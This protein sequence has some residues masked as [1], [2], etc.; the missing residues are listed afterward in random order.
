MD[1]PQIETTRPTARG[2]LADVISRESLAEMAERERLQAAHLE[3]RV[4]ALLRQAEQ[5][6]EQAQIHAVRAGLLQE[7][8]EQ[9]TAPA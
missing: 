7:L 5:L 2:I 4:A 8:A 6:A 1:A 9:K 3:M